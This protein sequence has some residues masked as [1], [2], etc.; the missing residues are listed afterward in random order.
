MKKWIALITCIACG[1]SHVAS[2]DEIGPRDEYMEEAAAIE[3]EDGVVA[4]DKAPSSVGKAATDG[5]NAA[6]GSGVGKY[7]LA[8]GAIAVG[9]TALI[10]VS[11]NSGHRHHGHSH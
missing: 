2:A 8:A 11:K 1:F 6:K 3:P 5:S 4:D 10:L 9:I 7:L